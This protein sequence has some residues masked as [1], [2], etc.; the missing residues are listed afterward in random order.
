MKFDDEFPKRVASARARLGI[1]QAE[2]AELVGVV[3]RQIAAYENG[4]SKPRMGALIRLSKA[5]NTSIAWLTEG[6]PRL[7]LE[8]GDS[9]PHGEIAII[10]TKSVSKWLDPTEDHSSLI[11][12]LHKTTNILGEFSFAIIN[13]D[14]AMAFSGTDGYGFPIGSIVY[15]DPSIEV[16]DQDFV[17]AIL[18]NGNC[19]FR[20]IFM[21]FGGPQLNALDSRYPPESVK[22][23]AE[24]DVGPTLISAVGCSYQLPA[25][26]RI[27]VSNINLHVLQKALY[28][29]PSSMVDGKDE[30]E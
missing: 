4:E 14:P 12:K 5:L 7:I 17:L 25:M 29:T 19:I 30:K 8:R 11:T 2:L 23:M 18:P 9:D 6:A 24:D 20:Q 1:T 13:S 3:Q 10:D 26:N 21:G 28:P 27:E 22:N 16:K 15:F